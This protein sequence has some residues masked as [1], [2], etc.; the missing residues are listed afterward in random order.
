MSSFLEYLG[1]FLGNSK[2]KSYFERFYEATERFIESP[3]VSYTF[4]KYNFKF[5]RTLK[6]LEHNT[7]N[8]SKLCQ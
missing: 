4:L 1:Y 7:C 3:M 2:L 8:H 5:P 6:D